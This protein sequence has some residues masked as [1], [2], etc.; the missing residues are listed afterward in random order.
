MYGLVDAQLKSFH[1]F[2][3]SKM[4]TQSSSLNCLARRSSNSNKTL[5]AK[6]IVL[7]ITMFM[8]FYFN[9]LNFLQ[10]VINI[11][12]LIFLHKIKYRQKFF[13]SINIIMKVKALDIY[14]KITN[15]WIFNP[16]KIVFTG[17]IVQSNPVS[18]VGTKF[19]SIN[20][21]KRWWQWSK[22]VTQRSNTLSLFYS[23]LYFMSNFTQQSTR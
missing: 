5:A 1:L 20:N 16:N 21:D 7:K 2:I 22:I 6:F 12:Q 8:N 10:N 4:W 19:F 15:R 14:E 23:E 17:Y 3:S 18:R 9:K 11:N 13:Y